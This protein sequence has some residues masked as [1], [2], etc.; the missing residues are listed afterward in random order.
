MQ[1]GARKYTSIKKKKLHGNILATFGI[2]VGCTR[3]GMIC[4]WTITIEIVYSALVAI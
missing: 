2:Y 4:T 3:V 1:S